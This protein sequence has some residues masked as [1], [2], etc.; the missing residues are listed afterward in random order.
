MV[1]RA[2][3]FLSDA[4]EHFIVEN[5]R[6]RPAEPIDPVPAGAA[7]YVALPGLFDLQVN[8]SGGRDYSAPDLTP[9][10]VAWVCRRMIE[11][12]TLYHLPTI[13]TR[14][15]E[16]VLHNLETIEQARRQDPLVA[17]VI[18][19]YHVE[20]PYIS[21]EEGPRGAHDPDYIRDPDIGEYREWQAAAANG[22]R[23]V[24]VAPERRGSIRFIERLVADGVVPSIGH[25]AATPEEIRRAVS[26]GAR[27]STHL[28][29]GSHRLVPRLQNYIW[30][31]LA[32]DDLTAGLIAD[33]FHLPEAVI[34]TFQRTKGLTRIVLVS[35][36]SPMA[37][38]EPGSYIWDKIAVEVGEDGRIGVA[39]S[40]YFAGAWRSLAET[41]PVFMQA[42]GMSQSET[43]PLATTAPADIVG[44][45]AW[46]RG[47]SSRD[48]VTIFAH[49]AKSLSFQPVLSALDGIIVEGSKL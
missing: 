48:S 10:D 49:D 26:A 31:Q 28:G 32:A 40:P 20:G 15:Q 7:Q 5:A 47:L 33:G 23:I 24:T 11:I 1:I 22:L 44:L 21:N 4:W 35:D 39:G 46:Y 3:S 38:L 34:R 17:A 42:T 6:L 13:I 18:K 36:L 8:G 14:P 2:Y 43:L 30:E 37:G 19:G 25:S 27:M 9:S 45:G 41:L 16:T 12:G 29:N